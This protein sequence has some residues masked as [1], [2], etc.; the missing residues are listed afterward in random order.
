[1]IWDAS[2]NQKN[3]LL[4][5]EHAEHAEQ[6]ELRRNRKTTTIFTNQITVCH[7]KS[8]AN[9]LYSI[10]TIYGANIAADNKANARPNFQRGNWNYFAGIDVE[11][12]YTQAKQLITIKKM[13]GNSTLASKY[14]DTSKRYFF[15]RGHL[16]PDGNKNL[17]LNEFGSTDNNTSCVGDFIDAAS[18]DATYYYI[19]VAP[20]WQSFN[21]GNWKELETDTRNLAISRNINL[22]TYT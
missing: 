8:N 15:S 3:P 6:E 11:T 17:R 21:N 20:Q 9:T 2:L 22:V 4:N 10:N 1:M 12:A 18:Q 7:A 16:A 5:R 14:I 13:V 19:N